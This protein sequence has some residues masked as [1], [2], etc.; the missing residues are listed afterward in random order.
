MIYKGLYYIYIVAKNTVSQRKKVIFQMINHM[1]FLLFAIYLY[2]YVYQ[3]LPSITSKLPFPNAIWS[4]S[5]YFVVFWLALRNIEKIFRY[6]I[7]SG[8][9]EVYLLRP[10]GYVWQKVFMQIGQGLMP[11]MWALILSVG[12]DYFIVGLPNMNMPIFLWIISLAVVFILSQT[13][14]C[15]IFVLCGLS[16]FWLGN[17]E[18]IYFVVSKLI[19][20]FG[21]AWVPV[22]FFPRAL[23]VV[24]EYSPF[25]ASMAISYAMYPNFGEHVGV[26]VL[27]TLFWIVICGVLVNIISKKAM[28]KLSVNG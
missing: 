18:P 13:L 22:A 2:K 14:T 24:A 23:Q 26:L 27:N 16:G 11:F 12:V 1:I 5:M 9:V 10:I 4:M 8:D 15:L 20:V 19:M 28:Q 25:G 3:L 21:G 6:D 17:S 7:L